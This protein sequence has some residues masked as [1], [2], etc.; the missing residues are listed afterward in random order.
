MNEDKTVDWKAMIDKLV[1]IQAQSR[2]SAKKIILLKR[3]F[4]I[5]E[6][7]YQTRIK[8]YFMKFL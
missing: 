7:N 6:E 2:I 4:I 3:N 1:L 5:I 8:L